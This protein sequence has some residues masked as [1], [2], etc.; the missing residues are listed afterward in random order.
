MAILVVEDDADVRKMVV[1][2]LN[3]ENYQTLEA[4]NV[5][6]AIRLIKTIQI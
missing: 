5:K 4:E 6:K 3:S 2:M 1:N